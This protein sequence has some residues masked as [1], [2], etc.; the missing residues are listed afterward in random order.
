MSNDIYHYNDEQPKKQESSSPHC[1]DGIYPYCITNN[2]GIKLCEGCEE[3]LGEN[4]CKDCLWICFPITITIDTAII[5]PEIICY[6][7]NKCKKMQKM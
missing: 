1:T 4:T 3:Q 7:Y 5:I 6:I 2:T